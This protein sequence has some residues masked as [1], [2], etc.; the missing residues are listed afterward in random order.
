MKGYKVVMAIEGDTYQ[1]AV[2]SIL[3]GAGVLYLMSR[4][5]TPLTGCGPLCVFDKLEDATDL[6]ILVGQS[7]AIFEVEYTPAVLGV[8]YSSHAVVWEWNTSSSKLEDLQPNTKL[9]KSITL[10]RVIEKAESLNPRIW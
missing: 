6:V 5:T 9:A 2:I 1:S 4:E 3:G 7:A 8:D 10:R